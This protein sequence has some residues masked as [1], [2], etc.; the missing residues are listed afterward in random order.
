[1]LAERP[2]SVAA[3]PSRRSTVVAVVDAFVLRGL[4]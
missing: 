1:V 2:D 4:P 3:P